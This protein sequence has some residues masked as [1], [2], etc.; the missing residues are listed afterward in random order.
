M[1]LLATKLYVPSTRPSVLSRSRLAEQLNLGLLHPFTL[2]SAPAGYGKTTL[3]STWV[4]DC[5]E[6]VAWLSLHLSK[7]PAGRRVD[8][9][10]D[11]TRNGS[12]AIYR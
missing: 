10:V 5:G 4:A 7:A 3:V 6:S 11:R 12:I 8:R 1:A 9:T 2:I